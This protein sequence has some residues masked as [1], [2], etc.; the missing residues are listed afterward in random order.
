MI[1]EERHLVSEIGCITATNGPGNHIVTHEGKTH[2]VWQ[3]HTQDGYFNRVRTLDHATGT[4]SDPVILNEGVDNHARPILTIDHQGYLHVVLS[5]HGSPIGSRRSL[6]PND[7]SEWTE[8]E[9]AGAGTYPILLCGLDDTLFLTMRS[10]VSWNG[11]ELFVRP[12]GGPWRE[13][14]KPIKR[15]DEYEGYAAYTNG[16]A[17]APDGTIHMVWD[18]FETRGTWEQ[19]GL[20]QYVSYMCSR[21]GAAT[22]EKADGTAIKA[23]ARPEQ[24]DV[25]ARYNAPAGQVNPGSSIASGGSIAVDSSG[26]PVVLYVSHMEMPGQI[27]MATPDSE[28]KWEQRSIEVVEQAYPDL[29]PGSCSRSVTSS[30]DGTIYALLELIPISDGWDNGKP[31]GLLGNPD[32]LGKQLV[33]LI[34]S[35]GGSNWSVA[36]AL[37]P[38]RFFNRANVERHTS[39]FIPTSGRKPSFIY[40]DGP[41]C[42]VDGEVIQTNVYLVIAR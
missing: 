4:M 6:R 26:R 19:Y 30:D 9:P 1:Q 12:P 17:L 2:V 36:P 34:S 32:G 11:T 37:E 15:T 27:I 25:F 10:N 40:H 39:A 21:D 13:G 5:G 28:G 31:T 41:T 3:D 22:W 8:E 29:R 14:T 23:P 7:A 16:F 20:D 35:D 42:G 24:M 18:F 38:G 33:W